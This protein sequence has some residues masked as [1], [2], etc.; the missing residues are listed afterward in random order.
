MFLS[1]KFDLFPVGSQFY[2][3]SRAGDHRFQKRNLAGLAC[4]FEDLDDSQACGGIGVVPPAFERVDDILLEQFRILAGDFSQ[5]IHG[6]HFAMVFLRADTGNRSEM[7]IVAKKINAGLLD[8]QSAR[9]ISKAAFH[10]VI[11][12]MLS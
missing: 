8:C 4:Y 12:R 1:L 10:G 11:N 3:H 2:G 6:K 9:K 7:V 5:A